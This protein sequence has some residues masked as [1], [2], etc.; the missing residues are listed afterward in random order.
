MV[1]ARGNPVVPRILRGDRTIRLCSTASPRWNGKRLLTLGTLGPPPLSATRL[2]SGRSLCKALFLLRE[3]AEPSGAGRGVVHAGLW[4]YQCMSTQTL[5]CFESRESQ[6]F[7]AKARGEDD[8]RSLA[9]VAE[10]RGVA[11]KDIR[12]LCSAHGRYRGGAAC[13]RSRPR[14]RRPRPVPARLGIPAR[15]SH[16]SCDLRK[17]P[18]YETTRR[19]FNSNPVSARARADVACSVCIALS[20]MISSPLGVFHCIAGSWTNHAASILARRPIRVR[21]RILLPAT[22]HVDYGSPSAAC[23]GPPRPCTWVVTLVVTALRSGVV[24]R[25]LPQPRRT[26]QLC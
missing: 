22:V 3:V 12:C 14:P 23:R 1:P 25:K 13:R 11:D 10:S 4:H 21:I 26:R 16:R 20:R 6:P 9:A 2:R 19:A 5:Y 24:R 8:F 18:A 15:L 17:S 7:R